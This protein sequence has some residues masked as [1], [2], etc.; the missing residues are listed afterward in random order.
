MLAWPPKIPDLRDEVSKLSASPVVVNKPRHTN[1]SAVIFILLSISPE[2]TTDA[3]ID[4]KKYTKP[5]VTGLVHFHTKLRYFNCS[6]LQR[7][8]AE[9]MFA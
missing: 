3:D 1:V 4:L 6:Q 5:A 2:I 7:L 8:C 9:Y